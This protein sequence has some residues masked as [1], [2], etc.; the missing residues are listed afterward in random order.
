M[1]FPKESQYEVL[2][3]LDPPKWSGM[4]VIDGSERSEMDLPRL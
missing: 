2:L 1:E 3:V 4:L